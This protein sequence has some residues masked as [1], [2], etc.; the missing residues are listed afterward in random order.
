MPRNYVIGHIHRFTNNATKWFIGR[1]TFHRP[2]SL[3]WNPEIE[4]INIDASL[5]FGMLRSYDLI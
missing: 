2:P 4:T 1:M 5:M 3:H